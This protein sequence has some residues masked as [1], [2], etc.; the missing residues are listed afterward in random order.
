[1]VYNTRSPKQLEIIR[2]HVDFK[3][4]R[5]IDLGCGYGDITRGAVDDGAA[6]VVGV[7]KDGTILNSTANRYITHVAADIED[8]KPSNDY[9]VAICFSVLPYLKDPMRFLERMSRL[10][11]KSLIECQYVG[12]G[13]GF[14]RDDAEMKE[15]LLTFWNTA[16]PIG[17]TEV[18]YRN[19]ERTIWLCR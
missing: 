18:A 2:K 19:V 1:M 5:V 13:P 6:H 7:D 8:Y 4:K 14:V 17:K 9:D 15:I 10:A 3:G 11:D 12:D 16:L